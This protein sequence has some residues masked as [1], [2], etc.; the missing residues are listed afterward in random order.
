L[1]YTAVKSQ[2][3]D[4][5]SK[6]TMLVN[7]APN[8]ELSRLIRFANK[9]KKSAVYSDSKITPEFNAK[10]KF[11]KYH[12]LISNP[13]D[14]KYRLNNFYIDILNKYPLLKVSPW[15]MNRSVP[16]SH[17]CEYLKQMQKVL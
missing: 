6:A 12:T 2:V 15:E 1:F 10:V 3:H 9:V 5:S 7:N 4:W 16:D 17:L 8:N 14:R 13:S 11:M